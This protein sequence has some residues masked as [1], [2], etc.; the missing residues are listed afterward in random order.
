M[1][2]TT[3]LSSVNCLRPSVRSIA[4]LTSVIAFVWV[5]PP[6]AA[7]GGPELLVRTK[8]NGRE[9]GI[10]EKVIVTG[11][12]AKVSPSPGGQ[13]EPIEPFAIFFKLRTDGGQTKEN[14]FVRVGGSAGEPLGW[15]KKSDV[16]DW[17]TRFVLE[18]LQPTPDR[19][20]SIEDESGEPIARLQSVAEGKRRLAFITSSPQS[21]KGDDTSY[22]VV[23][24][25]GNVQTEGT[26]GTLS[27]EGKRLEDLRLEVVFVLESTDFMLGKYGNTV[28]LIELVKS[29]VRDSMQ[30]FRSDPK[31]AEVV[32]FGIIEYQDNTAKAQFDTRLTCPLTNDQS[33]IETAMA[34]ITPLELADD[35]PDDVI[36]GLATAVERVGWSENS[37]KHIILMGAASCQKYPQSRRQNQFGFDANSFT[38][39]YEP[40]TNNPLVGWNT[41]GLTI[42]DLVAR[43]NPEGGSS[44]DRARSA[45]AFHTVLAGKD[46][47]QLNPELVNAIDQIVRMSDEELSRLIDNIQHRL[48]LT[49]KDAV[50]LL[51]D[52][53]SVHLYNKYRDIAREQYRQIA[54][55]NGIEGIYLAVEPD[56]GAINSAVRTIKETLSVSFG[57]LKGVR[58]GRV[59]EEELKQQSNPITQ[60]FY[61]L[62]GA[63]ANKFK[64]EPTLQGRARVRD[65]RGREVAQRK[66]LVSR[67]ELQ[68]LQSTFDAIYKKFQAST[69]KEEHQD[70][71]QI[72]DKLKEVTVTTATGQQ[73]APDVALRDVISDLP[74]KTGALDITPADIA[75][76]SADTFT[77]WLNKLQ[78]AR[79]RVSDLLDGKAAQWLELSSR[80]QNEKFTFVRLNDLP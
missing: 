6:Q 18:P 53:F 64:D 24:Y 63:A 13:G 73:L 43:A 26:G 9:S 80:A 1:L 12:R 65:E 22:P 31:L 38:H 11:A 23:V 71:T 46:M 76:M 77:Q 75:V 67:D 51:R 17:N 52:I 37:S 56:A 57:T 27:R 7:L 48:D 32:R 55:N 70:V 19:A 35:F 5:A 16:T 62:V 68:R 14:G 58:E 44:A 36:S 28:P 39:M 8:V 4:V 30:A 66:I 10:Y 3:G 29:L 15:I 42:E 49:D 41:S 54:R 50:G 25:T 72:L 79:F 40:T 69:A 74:L 45:I 2:A 21:E 34:K 78:T 20:F 59:G 61:A 47:K 60:R 33:E